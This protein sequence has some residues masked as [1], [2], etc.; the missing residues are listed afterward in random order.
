VRDR[1]LDPLERWLLDWP[2]IVL[3]SVLLWRLAAGLFLWGGWQSLSNQK[4]DVTALMSLWPPPGLLERQFIALVCVASLLLIVSNLLP[5]D[6]SVVGGMLSAGLALLLSVSMI[7]RDG[8]F[9]EWKDIDGVSVLWYV[10][11]CTGLALCI[12]L[13][14]I[15]HQRWKSELRGHGIEWTRRWAESKPYAARKL[16]LRALRY[17]GDWETE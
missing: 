16:A 10:V 4:P 3:G 6:Y 12:V 15:G 5:R 17:M 13:A 2:W 11:S 14:A 7:P 8:L 9:I 1:L